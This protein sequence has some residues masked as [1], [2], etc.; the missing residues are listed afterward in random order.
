MP[1]PGAERQHRLQGTRDP[2]DHTR[3]LA[4]KLVATL[5]V[6][7]IGEGSLG[8]E[9]SEQLRGVSRLDVPGSNAK[10]HRV[11][12][13][14]IEKAAAAPVGHVGGAGIGVE[15]VGWLPVRLGDLADAVDTLTN[16]GP[17]LGDVGGARKYTVDTDDGDGDLGGI[18]LRLR[19]R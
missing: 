12:V 9:Q 6:A 5:S 11:E 13:H 18:G 19:H 14:R 7:G 4:V 15:V 10:L 16:I 8:D 17:V 3:A 1:E 2:E